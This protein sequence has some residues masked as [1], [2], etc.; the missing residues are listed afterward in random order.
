MVGARDAAETAKE[1]A[2]QR[3]CPS[4]SPRARL[5]EKQRATRGRTAV[6]IPTSLRCPE[7]SSP[8]EGLS[9]ADHSARRPPQ[10]QADSSAVPLPRHV[11]SQPLLPMHRGS[12][13]GQVH[14]QTP[15]SRTLRGQLRSLALASY[16]PTLSDRA[17]RDMHVAE[18]LRQEAQHS[19]DAHAQLPILVQP[20]GFLRRRLPGIGLRSQCGRMRTP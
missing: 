4:A 19:L 20:R 18:V 16:V 2:S 17:A 7:A 8:R 14:P 3:P 1:G 13:P 12:E 5:S 10:H 15:R 6:A 11:G 9:V